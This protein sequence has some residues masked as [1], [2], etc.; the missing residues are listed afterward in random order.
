MAENKFDKQVRELLAEADATLVRSKKHAIYRFPSGDVVTMSQTPG[1]RRVGRKR[2]A[3]VK[4]AIARAQQTAAHPPVS[5]VTVPTISARPQRKRMVIPNQPAEGPAGNIEIPE[6]EPVKPVLPGGASYTPFGSLWELQQHLAAMD[7]F[8]EL[9]IGGRVRVLMKTM[10]STVC[11]EP[12]PTLFC[13]AT[14]EELDLV[15]SRPGKRKEK[16]HHEF[17]VQVMARMQYTCGHGY[18]PG[19]LVSD[20]EEG[21]LLVDVASLSVLS[22]VWEDIQ[23][24]DVEGSHSF[25]LTSTPLW[26]DEGESGESVLFLALSP[27]AVKKHHVHFI[28]DEGWS[29]PAATRHVIEALRERD[30]PN[31]KPRPHPVFART[32]TPIEKAREAMPPGMRAQLEEQQEVVASRWQ[33][34]TDWLVSPI[35]LNRTNRRENAETLEWVGRVFGF[36]FDNN[37]RYMARLA[38]EE[39][40]F[41]HIELWFS[42][43]NED[44]KARFVEAVREDGYSDSDSEVTGFHPPADLRLLPDLKSPIQLFDNDDF[45]RVVSAGHLDLKIAAALGASAG[46]RK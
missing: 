4:Q 8:W 42:F 41:R 17:M 40:D 37:V 27:K 11:M 7:E 34:E 1:D 5:D 25:M 13:R 10:P 12:V 35:T 24:L 20:P 16:K 22:D 44:D 30:N 33:K 21:D 26:N 39:E 46:D 36:A 28:T 45:A 32:L 9:P 6:L 19:L 23:I 43:L 38:G 18:Y 15:F 14:D 2:V 31:Y 3:D 29:N